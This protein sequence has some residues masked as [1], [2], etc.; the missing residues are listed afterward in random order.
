MNRIDLNTTLQKLDG[1]DW[2]EPPGN[3]YLVTACYYLRKKP[4]RDFTTEDLRI[5][6]G[7]H[8]SLEYLIPLALDRLRADPLAEG[9]YYPG[10]LL[11]VVL[12]VPAGYWEANREA[13]EVIG[14]IV[15]RAQPLPQQLNGVVW[16]PSK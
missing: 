10:D 13:R 5:M 2:G 1:R 6:I 15:A 3:S 12:T 14:E 9:D 4:L 16:P 8:M 7:Q 11:K